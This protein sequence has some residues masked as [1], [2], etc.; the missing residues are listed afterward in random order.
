M[1]WCDQQELLPPSPHRR[2]RLAQ[3]NLEG[4]SDPFVSIFTFVQAWQ[5]AQHLLG[6]KGSTA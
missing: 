2:F 6:P 1:W 3:A 5:P 4:V